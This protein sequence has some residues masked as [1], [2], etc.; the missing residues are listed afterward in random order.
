M[1]QRLAARPQWRGFPIP[2]TTLIDQDGKPNFKVTDIAAWHICVDES[3]CALCGDPLDYWVY[4]MG[5]KEHVEIEQFFDMAMHEEC[6]R[7]AAEV[8]PYIATGRAYGW[9]IGP[10]KGAT[11]FEL[12]PRE[13]MSNEGVPI[14]L[15]RG[16]RNSIRRVDDNP[17]HCFVRTGT[18]QD[19]Q[20]I[21]HFAH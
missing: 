13:E 5:S 15:A 7:Y 21:G 1:P 10:T 18:L 8:C 14:F 16:R 20:P 4:Y 19:V 6:A 12:A 9:E 2:F 11:V 17:K 3:R